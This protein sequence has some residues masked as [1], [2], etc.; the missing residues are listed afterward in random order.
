[1]T[2]GILVMGLILRCW[3]IRAVLEA[4]LSEEH[5]CIIDAQR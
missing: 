2:D 1:M 5:S 3:C 4:N